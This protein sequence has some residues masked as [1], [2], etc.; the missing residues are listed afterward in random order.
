M[1]LFCGLLSGEEI[2]GFGVYIWG[3]P[4]VGS[5][6]AAAGLNKL[7]KLMQ[8][9]RTCWLRVCVEGLQDFSRP[10]FS[11]QYAGA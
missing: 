6:L 8:T 11:P 9:R 1:G 2:D 5:R 10:L 3:T 4:Y 7:I